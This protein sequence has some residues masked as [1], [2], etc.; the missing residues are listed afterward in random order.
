MK[1]KQEQDQVDDI[2]KTGRG[3]TQFPKGRSGN[4][5]GRPQGIKG[6][7]G[8]PKISVVLRDL[9]W[10]YKHLADPAKGTPQQEEFRKLCRTNAIKFLDLLTKHEAMNKHSEKAF[11][12]K[13]SR[14][15]PEPEEPVDEGT[16]R[17]VSMI[18]RLLDDF[19]AE[20]RKEDAELAKRPDAAHIAG[21]LQKTL[22]EALSREALLL[23]RVKELER[24]QPNGTDFGI[25]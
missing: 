24:A 23:D 1:T 25:V 17:V 5:S 7:P 20:Q 4:P 15:D 6:K 19:G 14:N 21:T 8:G 2:K 22:T 12:P 18:D 11:S 9:R 16:D 13:D 10:A 3:R